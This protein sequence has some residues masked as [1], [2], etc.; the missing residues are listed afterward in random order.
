MNGTIAPSTSIGYTGILIGKYYLI[1]NF[2]IRVYIRYKI[3]IA[4]YILKF[5]LGK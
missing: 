3:H 5:Q 1:T 2:L 4:E